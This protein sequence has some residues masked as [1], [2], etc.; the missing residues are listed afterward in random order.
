MFC[1]FVCTSMPSISALY[2]AINCMFAA[3]LLTIICSAGISC[4]VMNA[5]WQKHCTT[6]CSAK[7]VAGWPNAV[8]VSL[9]RR[10]EATCKMIKYLFGC[11]DCMLSPYRW[12]CNNVC[13]ACQQF[14]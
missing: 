10:S 14:H 12:S 11:F 9:G 3:V 8:T 13:A 4:C 1:R 5:S 7:Q 6:I 2:G